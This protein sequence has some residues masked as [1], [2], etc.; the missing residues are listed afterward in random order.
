V[1]DPALW[2]PPK[3]RVESRE[4][5][6]LREVAA[7]LEKA[8]NEPGF[9]SPALSPLAPPGGGFGLRIPFGRKPPPPAQVVPAPAR[10]ASLAADS[11]RNRGDALHLYY[12]S[13][14]LTLP[15]A[16]RAG[17]AFQ[18]SALLP[19]ARD[20]AAVKIFIDRVAQGS[21]T[22]T[23]GVANATLTIQGAGSHRI[24]VHIISDEGYP[25]AELVHIVNVG[26]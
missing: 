15:A 21:F 19:R 24:L 10:L 20:H 1:R 25:P 23:G 6:A 12:G 3:P 11:A 2:T 5:R 26:I 18:L 16:L 7:R 13:F 4:E 22:T 9:A 17:V 8:R 14:T